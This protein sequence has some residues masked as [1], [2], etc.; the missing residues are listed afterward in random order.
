MRASTTLRRTVLPLLLAGAIIGGVVGLRVM[1]DARAREIEQREGRAESVLLE[2]QAVAGTSHEADLRRAIMMLGAN[3]VI[4]EIVVVRGEPGVVTAA[5][6]FEWLGRSASALPADITEQLTAGSGSFLPVFSLN[7]EAHT[8]SAAASLRSLKTATPGT[9]LSDLRAYVALNLKTL[10]TDLASQQNLA[11]LALVLGGILVIG[12][13]ALWL[14]RIPLLANRRLH[15]QLSE[16]NQLLSSVGHEL[17]TPLTVVTGF[18]RLLQDDW[19]NLAEE[20]RREMVT[21]IVHQGD[22]LANILEDLLTSGQAEAGMLRLQ[23]EAVDLSAEAATIIEGLEGGTDKSIEAATG[24]VWAHADS[25]RVRQVIRNLLTNAL[26]YGG[27]KISVEASRRDSLAMLRVIDDGTGVAEH[28]RE[29]I[30]EPFER[31][32]TTAGGA[33][34]LGL[35]LA[36]SRQLARAMGGDLTYQYDEGHSTFEFTAPALEPESASSA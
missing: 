18:G 36:I 24:P 29:R 23:A 14:Q 8:L 10:S 5:S 17:R 13:L 1:S 26:K 27:G 7:D 30:F 19:A 20:E 12:V 32:H 31:A 21:M 16:K 22:D 15:H 9:H 25:R 11:L 6:E 34:S 4:E 2:I 33:Q 28:M 35:G 3:P